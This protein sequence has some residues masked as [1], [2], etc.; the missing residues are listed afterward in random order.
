MAWRFLSWILSFKSEVFD[1]VKIGVL[2]FQGDFFEHCVLLKSMDL[3]CLEVRTK[4]D[5]G[6]CDALI[7]PGGESTVINSFLVE[8]SLDSEIK[9]LV[10]SGL[11]LLGTCAGAIICAKKIKGKNSFKPL[12]L[13]DVSI[14]RNSYGRQID[15]FEAELSVRRKKIRGV[16]IRA[17]VILS[18]GKGV[19]VLAEF[20]GK[21]VL[22][23]QKNVIISTFHPELVGERLVH[24]LLLKEIRK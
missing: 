6:A 15:S 23:K 11:P 16:F 21:P 5:L 12:N 7:I 18:C 4:K 22:A 13:I 1:L 3:G 19:E 17:P 20:N 8:S 2:A 9:K 14:E 24:E 10:A